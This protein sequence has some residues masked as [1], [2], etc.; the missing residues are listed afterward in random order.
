MT[1]LAVILVASALATLGAP[2]A[3]AGPPSGDVVVDWNRT[4]LNAIV[5]AGHPGPVQILD[6]AI[7]HAAI[8]D[9]VNSVDGRHSPYAIKVVPAP[10]SASQQAAAAT[11]AHRVLLNLFPAQQGSLD[12]AYQQSM[13]EVP[14]GQAEDDGVSV[15]EQ[16]AAGILALR[17]NDGR[18]ANVPYQPGSG[19]GAWVPTPPFP[20]NF[21]A[22]VPWVAK[23]TPFTARS[24]NQFR[25]DPP[26][27]L[28]SDLYTEDYE[29]V[30][31]MGSRTGSGRTAEQTAIAEFFGEPPA[32]AWSRAVQDIALARNHSVADSAR[33][34]ALVNLAAA[35]AQI[36]C[37]EN[38]YA[39]GFWRPIT[40][41]RAGG[42]DTN[43]LTA[44]DPSWEPLL[45]TPPFP[46][47]SSG[48][49]TFTG[50]VTQVLADFYGTDHFSFTMSSTFSGT[51][52]SYSRFSDVNKEVIDGRVWA[53]SHFRT[54]DT[55]GAAAGNR[56][57]H[58]V[59]KNVARPVT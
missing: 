3:Q 15:G 5:S 12:A 31:T 26:P 7:V 28:T 44:G 38:K 34:F 29:E 20:P 56:I 57:G 27:A 40:A 35:D 50:A 17:S 21:P 54:A 46:E 25:V 52:R 48:H 6:L 47:Y 30:K 23:V 14:D 24:S 4:A 13:G 55:V 51:R 43:P 37:W 19:P 39:Y 59:S 45:V 36:S 9:A 41:I 53:G 1:A 22:L 2:R 10:P 8:Y 16:A 11:A 42:T 58:W 33:L 18:F 32:T 49:A